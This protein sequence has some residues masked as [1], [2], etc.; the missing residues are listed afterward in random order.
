M[1]CFAGDE[2][3][4]AFVVLLI[5]LSVSIVCFLITII[6]NKNIQLT[7]LPV[8]AVIAIA[9]L[10]AMPVKWNNTYSENFKY[11][12][13]LSNIIMNRAQNDSDGYV[14]VYEKELNNVSY[15]DS[16]DSLKEFY[17]EGSD[18]DDSQSLVNVENTDVISYS[19][20]N[21]ACCILPSLGITLAR[22]MNSSWQMIFLSGKL[23]NLFIILVLLSCLFHLAIKNNSKMT[24]PIVSIVLPLPSIII[25]CCE[26]STGAVLIILF[27][28]LGIV[29]FL[30]KNKY[31]KTMIS[32]FYELL[33]VNIERV[34][35]MVYIC[36]FI[37]S[38]WSGRTES[39]IARI[40]GTVLKNGATVE[41]PFLTYCILISFTT[42]VYF[43]CHNN[44]NKLKKNIVS[45][46][47]ISFVNL[48]SILL[49]TY[50]II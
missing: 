44:Y 37:C 16:V 15:T 10:I 6:V 27:I 35:F 42:G 2:M 41:Y 17:L 32:R 26:Y 46:Y 20:Q 23:T 8:F 9:Y 4:S 14:R 12:Y 3:N 21:I 45:Q 18:K 43:M 48:I 24:I 13:H 25:C 5:L 29:L 40:A 1:I 47:I 28:I 22:L 30:F 19:K 36:L 31:L 7:I 38:M 49:I 33:G 50:E 11:S 34:L 39:L